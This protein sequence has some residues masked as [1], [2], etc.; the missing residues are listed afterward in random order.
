MKR[1]ASIG[2]LPKHLQA[3]AKELG[4]KLAKHT[5]TEFFESYSITEF[6]K[7][8]VTL[9]YEIVPTIDSDTSRGFL[10]GFDVSEPSRISSGDYV[11]TL[12]IYYVE[13][14]P[15]EV[16]QWTKK[17]KQHRLDQQADMMI[18]REKAQANMKLR[19]RL[20]ILK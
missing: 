17:I 16:E 20:K 9:G 2:N 18:R 6:E 12:K 5:G 4:G 7:S 11:A 13:C 8:A 10:V 1:I 19:N 15:S 14:T 3:F